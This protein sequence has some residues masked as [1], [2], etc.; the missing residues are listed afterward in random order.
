MIASAGRALNQ[1]HSLSPADVTALAADPSIESR[2]EVA[3]K[4]GAQ[5]DGL[6][7]GHQQ[8]RPRAVLDLLVRDVAKRVREALAETV[9]HCLHLP[10]ALGGPCT[11]R[12]RYRDCPANPRAQS[13]AA[14]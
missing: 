12:R 4:F 2:V 6:Q 7:F 11:G 3:R 5:L 10:R 8:H 9:A 14:G 1:R 13:G